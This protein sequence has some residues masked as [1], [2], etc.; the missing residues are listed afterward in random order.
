M[1]SYIIT[2]LYLI[3]DKTIVS[4]LTVYRSDCK[5]IM[6]LIYKCVEYKSI[7]YIHVP[8]QLYQNTIRRPQTWNVKQ[9]YEIV[10]SR[11]LKTIKVT[12]SG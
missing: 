4:R 12:C 1:L 5:A 8:R 10:R 7:W 2:I 11:E 3:I 9:D 6:L